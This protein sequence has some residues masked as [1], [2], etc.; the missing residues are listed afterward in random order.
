MS[1]ATKQSLVAEHLGLEPATSM[2]LILFN[3]A[4]EATELLVAGRPQ[5]RE[6]PR[7]SSSSIRLA[8]RTT[9]ASRTASH[10]AIHQMSTSATLGSAACP[11][12]GC[13]DVTSVHAVRAIDRV[14][15]G[16]IHAI[17]YDAPATWPGCDRCR[18]ATR[19]HLVSPCHRSSCDRRLSWAGAARRVAEALDVADE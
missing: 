12:T 6:V 5:H 15:G 9:C 19:C 18:T 14:L 2:P 13:R 7:R 10:C 17:Q 3:I 11:P 8:G 4:G 16:R 1:S